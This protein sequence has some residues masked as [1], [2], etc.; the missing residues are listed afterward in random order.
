MRTKKAAAAMP[1]PIA[2]VDAIGVEDESVDEGF[3]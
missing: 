3:V 1:T 2:T